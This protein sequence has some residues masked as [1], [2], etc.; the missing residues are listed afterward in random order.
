MKNLNRPVKI[1]SGEYLYKGYRIV[2]IG[3]YEP[4]HRIV[5]EAEN[6]ETG[7]GDFHAYTKR[8]IIDFIDEYFNQEKGL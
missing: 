1:K 4:E 5:W 3:Y 2:C 7:C 8:E 6:L